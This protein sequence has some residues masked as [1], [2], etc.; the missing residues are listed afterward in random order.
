MALLALTLSVAG[1]KSR[2]GLFMDV[3]EEQDLEFISFSDANLW[4][5]IDTMGSGVAA[6]DYDGD[7]DLDLYLCSG[8]AI[9]DAYLDEANERPDAL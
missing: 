9:Q 2:A 3:A 8:H 7:G 1:C 6:G 4:Y 5:L